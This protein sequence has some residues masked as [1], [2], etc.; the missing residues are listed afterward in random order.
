LVNFTGTSAITEGDHFYV[1]VFTFGDGTTTSE[2]VNNA[3]Y[4]MELEETGDNTSEFVGSIEYIMINQT[5]AVAATYAPEYSK[6]L[7][8]SQLPMNL[9]VTDSES[10]KVTLSPQNMRTIH[11]QLSSSSSIPPTS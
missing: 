4:R 6:V 8:S 9:L 3:I 11:Y 2:R 5:N 7:C 10:Q 1:D